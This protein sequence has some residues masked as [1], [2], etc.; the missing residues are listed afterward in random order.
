M[1]LT[2]LNELIDGSKRL[3]GRWE[4]GKNHEIQ[5]RSFEKNEEIKSKG[6]S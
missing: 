6:P 3:R 5:Y 2:K 1:K 4:I